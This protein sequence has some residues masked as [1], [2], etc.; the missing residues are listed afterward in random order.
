MADLFG[1]RI[2]STYIYVLNS[3]PNTAIITNGDGSDIDWDGNKIVLKTGYQDI[4]GVKNFNSIPTVQGLEIVFKSNPLSGLG[5]GNLQMAQNSE[6]SVIFAGNVNTLDGDYSVIL[7]GNNNS[8][9]GNNSAIGVG[10]YND[11]I[12]DDSFILAG[13]QNSLNGNFSFIG[14]GDGNH[15]T[16][17]LS[18]INGGVSNKLVG[19]QSS[20]SAGN[21]NSISGNRSFIGG[22][23]SNFLSG[24]SSLVGGGVLNRVI[25]SKSAI[26][27]GEANVIENGNFSV[28]VGGDDNTLINSDNAVIVGG[29]QNTG[30]GNFS[31]VVGGKEN[32][33]FGENSVIVGGKNNQSTGENSVIVGGKNNQS[34]GDNIFVGS[35][36]NGKIFSI[37]SSTILNGENNEVTL[38]KDVV[39]PI[40]YQISIGGERAKYIGLGFE[41]TKFPIG[42]NLT[43]DLVKVEDFEQSIGPEFTYSEA[44]GFQPV[45]SY[46][47]DQG[48]YQK[49]KFASINNGIDNLLQ[50]DFSTVINGSGNHLAGGNSIIYGID[51]KVSGHN[52]DIFGGSGNS[53]LLNFLTNEDLEQVFDYTVFDFDGINI[54]DYLQN[55]LILN[56]AKNIIG[57]NESNEISS[58]QGEFST[59]RNFTGTASKSCQIIGGEENSVAAINATILN[60]KRNRINPVHFSLYNHLNFRNFGISPIPEIIGMEESDLIRDFTSTRSPFEA[61]SLIFNSIRC[62]TDGGFDSI[63]ASVNSKIISGQR[64]TP[65]EGVEQPV[66]SSFNNIHASLGCEI[67]SSNFSSIFNGMG[68][69]IVSTGD[70]TRIASSNSTILNGNDNKIDVEGLAL[71][72]FSDSD[73]KQISTYNLILNGRENEMER[74]RTTFST[75]LNGLRNKIN[76]AS[77]GLVVGEENNLIR[78]VA[79]TWDTVN[80]TLIG[81]YRNT[82]K[83]SIPSNNS[84]KK[85][86]GFIW[87]LNNSVLRTRNPFIFS[88]N[89]RFLNTDPS[90]IVSGCDAPV[91]LQSEAH[92]VIDCDNVFLNNC[93]N[94]TISGSDDSS[95]SNCSNS[96]FSGLIDNCGFSNVDNSEVFDLYKCEITNS[97]NAEFSGISRSVIHSANQG[98]FANFL[99]CQIFGGNTISG[100]VESSFFNVNVFGEDNSVTGV[101]EFSSVFGEN[102]VLFSKSS[103]GSLRR[104]NHIF[105]NSNLCSTSQGSF[106]FGDS[107]VVS[108]SVNSFVFGN[109]IEINSSSYSQAFG[110][111]VNISGGSDAF[112]Q[113]FG[114]N[115]EI[116]SSNYSQAF[117]NNVEMNSSDLSKIFGSGI[118]ITGNSSFVFGENIQLKG[119]RCLIFGKNIQNLSNQDDCFIFGNNITSYHHGSSVIKDGSTSASETKD[120][121]ALY[122]DFRN[123]THINVPLWQDKFSGNNSS[124]EGTIMYSGNY[125]LLFNGVEWRKV[126]TSAI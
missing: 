23:T 122:L 124:R 28:I 120:D 4:S 64:N 6:G 14:A 7:A 61:N 89:P 74:S 8:M 108:G 25:G 32:E 41:F 98:E 96:T 17:N 56:G 79:S 87:G 26:L 123:G 29:L 68:N 21:N 126:E 9:S 48:F 86:A 99:S 60:G 110:N 84:T 78:D 119:D 47:F 93:E 76:D 116:N 46:W 39:Y 81:G 3:D 103:F 49:P 125:L 121:D 35:S 51:N 112:S 88:A 82:Y 92:E 77:H 107:N 13:T 66:Y 15:I 31:V 117:G 54:G 63:I 106:T 70:V 59:F 109:N 50:G 45:E 104:N 69:K 12:G 90:G 113:G 62:Q 19:D 44:S 10:T 65:T 55:N 101:Q 115:I 18:N 38:N 11:L 67:E 85:E 20:I 52:S 37:S 30:S 27:G 114:N 24:T 102:N 58:R 1:K 83:G 34:T 22:G 118:N 95:Y 73:Y 57:E 2:D 36:K 42:R 80:H 105:G 43:D 40:R 97:N 72:L 53:I 33:V 91:I 100:L 16:G 111:N 71:D 5:E 75:I 94:V